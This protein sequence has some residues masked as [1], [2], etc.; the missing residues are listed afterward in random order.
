MLE[1]EVAAVIRELGWN[2]VRGP[3]YNG[4]Y[5]HKGIHLWSI[6][7]VL[8]KKEMEDRGIKLDKNSK[9]G[10]TRTVRF[11]AVVKDGEMKPLRHITSS[12]RKKLGSLKGNRNRV[13]S[14]TQNTGS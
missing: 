1:A 4:K 8:S 9:P 10:D 6:K 13:K 14:N 11:M 7:S 5:A 3:Y 12:E 2:I